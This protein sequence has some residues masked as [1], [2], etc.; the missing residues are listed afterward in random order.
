MLA[1]LLPRMIVSQSTAENEK[2]KMI[3]TPS[4]GLYCSDFNPLSHLDL[5]MVKK[6]IPKSYSKPVSKIMPFSLETARILIQK[7][8]TTNFTDHG[9]MERCRNH[10]ALRN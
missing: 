2:Y 9:S 8:L 3:M 1:A 10:H 7:L 6:V 5:H 4:Q